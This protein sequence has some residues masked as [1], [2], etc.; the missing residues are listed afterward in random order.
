[1]RWFAFVIAVAFIATLNPHADAGEVAYSAY[2]GYGSP[3]ASTPFPDAA[4]EQDKVSRHRSPRAKRRLK[5][6][7]LMLGIGWAVPAAVGLMCMDAGI[8][9]VGARMMIPYYGFAEIGVEVA[10]EVIMPAIPLFIPSMVQLVGTGFLI[11]GAAGRADPRRRHLS[12]TPI[13]YREGG[14]GMGVS[15][16]M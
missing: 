3:T 4:F 2:T 6:G 12:A 5:I 10:D 16:T 15:V 7:G 8:P 14:G 9:A 13:I 1:M 11:S